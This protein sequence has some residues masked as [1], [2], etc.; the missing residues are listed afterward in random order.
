MSVTEGVF[1]RER[2]RGREREREREREA[3]VGVFCHIIRCFNAIKRSTI[4]K[5]LHSSRNIR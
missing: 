2:E 1:E 4:S 3:E 5:D